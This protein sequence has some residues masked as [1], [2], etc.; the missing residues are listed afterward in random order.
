MDATDTASDPTDTPAL[1]D[2]PATS[3]RAGV[4]ERMFRQAVAAAQRSHVLVD[5]DLALIGGALTAAQALDTASQVGGLKGG[6]LVAQLLTPYREALA[7]LRLPAEVAPADQPRPPAPGGADAE[8]A[9]LLG[10][11]F[12]T[13]SD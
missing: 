4:V 8:L 9:S 11:H 13:P 5:E 6:Y 1:F 10:D 7:A 2:V 3:T 12:G